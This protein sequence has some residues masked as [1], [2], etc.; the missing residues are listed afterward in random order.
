MAFRGPESLVQVLLADKVLDS[1]LNSGA[2]QLTLVFIRRVHTSFPSSKGLLYVF[3][4]QQQKR[5]DIVT[6]TSPHNLRPGSKKKMVF[7]TARVHP[8]ETPASYVCQGKTA[9]YGLLF[10]LF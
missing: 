8:G 9:L 6:I 1:N 7:I 4:F 10:P 5:L 3:F 2:L